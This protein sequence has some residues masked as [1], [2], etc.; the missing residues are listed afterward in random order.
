[1]SQLASCAHGLNTLLAGGP[2]PFSSRTSNCL[3][4]LLQ[5]LPGPLFNF[6]AY[7]GAITAKHFG[8]FPLLGIVLCYVGLFAPGV[9]IIFG[10]LPYWGRLRNWSP[11]RRALAGVSSCP[12]PSPPAVCHDV[13]LV[14]CTA[15]FRAFFDCP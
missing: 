13:T 1:M 6:A 5:G 2:L 14:G 9:L 15:A 11:Y 7:L 8:Y 4:L 10:V 12:P 3:A